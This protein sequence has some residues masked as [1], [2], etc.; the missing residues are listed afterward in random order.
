MFI[1]TFRVLR[2]QQEAEQNCTTCSFVIFVSSQNIIKINRSR[3]IW[4]A[5]RVDAW[6]IWEIHSEF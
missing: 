6:W 4:W 2:K 3:W 1:N 5:G